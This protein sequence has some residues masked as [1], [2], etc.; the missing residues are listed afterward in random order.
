M[1][2]QLGV[3]TSM[4]KE[5]VGTC[6]LEPK[7]YNENIKTKKNNLK[8]KKKKKKKRQNVFLLCSSLFPSPNEKGFKLSAYAFLKCAVIY[9]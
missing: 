5:E 8:K 1:I 9:R 2:K 4:K 3:N 7:A 6:Q